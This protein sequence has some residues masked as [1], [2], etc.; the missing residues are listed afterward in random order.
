MTF[1]D[2]LKRIPATIVFLS[3]IAVSFVT[4]KDNWEVFLGAPLAVRILLPLA[5]LALLVFSYLLS[6]RKDRKLLFRLVSLAAVF[7]CNVF[8]S[9]GTTAQ[10]VL[11]IAFALDLATD[12]IQ[13]NRFSNFAVTLVA[14][15]VS[16]SLAT[17]TIPYLQR[18]KTPQMVT[19]I[20][21]T[22]FS[23]IEEI[24]DSQPQQTIEQNEQS[25][26]ETEAG[27]LTGNVITND[28]FDPENPLVSLT[29]L[30]SAHIDKLM[31]FSCYDYDP[32]NTK[33][34]L[35][36]P[37]AEVS[38]S[39]T[40]YYHKALSNES[41]GGFVHTLDIEDASIYTDIRAVPFCDFESEGFARA[42]RDSYLF[43]DSLERPFSYRYNID[44]DGFYDPEVP[45]YSDYVLYRY[46][47]LPF[48]FRQVLMDFLD[49]HGIE[50][51]LKNRYR[52]VRE[53]CAMLEGYTYS[54]EPPALP[55]EEDPI[56]WFLTVSRT[57]YSKHF[58]AAE[59]LLF[60]MLGIPA[61]YCYGYLFDAPA[62]EK[63]TVTE[64]NA[65][66]FCQVYLDGRW[67]IASEVKESDKQEESSP[68]N[69]G[70]QIHIEID[71]LEEARKERVRI[72]KKAASIAVP[73][74][75][76]LALLIFLC[77]KFRPDTV[78]RID[79]SY[80]ALTSFYFIRDEI[81]SCM[82]KSRYSK[83][84][85]TEEDALLLENEVRKAKELYLYKKNLLRLSALSFYIFA[86]KIRAIA[87]NMFRK[88]GKEG[89]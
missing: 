6:I 65:Y 52:T 50:A 12:N 20:E 81:K 45:G 77:R 46:T 62:G 11:V 79:M 34:Y 75:L 85:P 51:D 78:Q 74:A 4:F 39:S 37:D 87:S 10:T 67:M 26:V 59:V 83:E 71:P 70:P 66:A 72:V 73:C 3:G 63:V 82:I 48:E 24:K 32:E 47:S 15:F 84:G 18:I 86:Q 88:Q 30:S 23:L 43:R 57:G 14:F 64:G 58:A 41:S 19:D 53:V 7:C 13:I 28:P 61:R 25:D 16:A 55:E 36:S 44:P 9:E 42:L 8:S 21:E 5:V 68:E 76:L 56:L 31:V 38:N 29:V 89:R 40:A 35:P 1:G 33:F 2:V 22:W 17:L 54:N 27:G 60:R 80:K 49:S 69:E